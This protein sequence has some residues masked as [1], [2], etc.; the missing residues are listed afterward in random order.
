MWLP[1]TTIL[2]SVPVILLVV[3][4][5]SPSVSYE[6]QGKLRGVVNVSSPHRAA[7][8]TACEN[9]SLRAG[10]T[11]ESLGLAASQAYEGEFTHSV[12]ARATGTNL[13][14]VEILLKR[15]NDDLRDGQT[16]I[17]EGRCADTQMHWKVSG[18]IPWKYLEHLVRVI[19]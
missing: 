2:V 12:T 10:L 15:V 9:G 5:P 17:L 8:R 4:V 3:F 6:S 7:L 13:A 11:N 19:E 1:T 18:D 14:R 16:V